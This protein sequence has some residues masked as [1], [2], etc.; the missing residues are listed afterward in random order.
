MKSWLFW[1]KRLLKKFQSYIGVDLYI[2]IVT[3][4]YY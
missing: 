2:I 1:N 3:V 4:E